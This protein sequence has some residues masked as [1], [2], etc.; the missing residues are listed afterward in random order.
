MTE[1]DREDQRRRVFA[2]GGYCCA[3]CGKPLCH[4]DTQPQ[5]AHRIANT[6]ANRKRYGSDVI[7]DDRN[8]W[9]VCSLRCNDACNIGGRPVEAALLS[10]QIQGMIAQSA[11]SPSGAT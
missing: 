2:R 3:I 9:P 7:D 6:K 5:L 1:I 10:A 11:Q 4:H 8:L